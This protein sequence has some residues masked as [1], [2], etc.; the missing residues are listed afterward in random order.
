MTRFFINIILFQR[1][2]CC[3]HNLHGDDV[4]CLQT[5]VEST[6][7]YSYANPGFNASSIAKSVFIC[8]YILTGFGL[9]TFIRSLSITTKS[10]S[11]VNPFL[12]E[13]G[14][15]LRTADREFEI[16]ETNS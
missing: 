16:E 6:Y 4:L 13:V 9:H 14:C 8:S 3:E 1:W 11:R 5:F 10:Q 7:L 2:R 12:I 15:E